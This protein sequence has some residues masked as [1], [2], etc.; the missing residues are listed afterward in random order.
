MGSVYKE[1]FTKPL[2]AGAKI[3]VRKGQRLAQWQDAKGKTRTAPLTAAGDRIAVEAGTYTAKFRDGSGIVRKITTGCRD[4]TA[5]ESVL[6]D[7][8][9]RAEKV[10]GGIL[11][12]DEAAAIDQQD[13]PLADH[14]AAFLEHQGAKGI[15]RKQIDETRRRFDRVVADGGFHRL[16][17]LNGTALERW[18]VARQEAGMGAT[19]RNAYR[20]ACITFG[21]WCVRNHRLLSNPFARVPKADAK[22]DPRRK[23]RALTEGELVKLL[24]MARRRPLLDAMMIRRGKRRGE[25]AAVLRGRDPPPAGTARP[26]TGVDLQ[27][28]GADRASQRRTGFAHRGASGAGRPPGFPGAGRCRRKEPG[29]LDDSASG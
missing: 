25:G 15:T 3:I 18:L 23:R 20:E 27:D 21:N 2:P 12:A 14:F 10:K 13:R 17:D 19:T 6:A 16:A 4:E 8:E 22:A 9:R 5:A 26:G 29:R 7:L 11:T 24:D 28:P 1:T